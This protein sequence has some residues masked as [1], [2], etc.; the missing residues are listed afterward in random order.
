MQADS[1]TG[2]RYCYEAREATVMHE[3]KNDAFVEHA[4]RPAEKTPD[5]SQV[6][7]ASSG[8]SHTMEDA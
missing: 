2:L 8:N 6:F 4:Q 3:A 7:I 1:H 5:Y